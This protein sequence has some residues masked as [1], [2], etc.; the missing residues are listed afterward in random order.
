MAKEYSAIGCY[1]KDVSNLD[2][3]NPWKGSQCLGLKHPNAF[4]TI[5]EWNLD[6]SKKL[7]CVT[8]KYELN[9]DWTVSKLSP[10]MAMTKL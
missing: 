1:D 4:Q 7:E 3:L 5:S 6:K 2:L 9:N 8:A 10:Y